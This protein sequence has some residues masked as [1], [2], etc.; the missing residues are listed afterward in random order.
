MTRVRARDRICVVVDVDWVDEG[1]LCNVSGDISLKELL[2]VFVVAILDFEHFLLGAEQFI[3]AQI[4]QSVANV[5]VEKVYKGA[6]VVVFGECLK[7]E[8]VTLILDVFGR[9][10]P[11]G[12]SPQLIANLVDSFNEVVLGDA[13]W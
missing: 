4:G 5:N 11:K 9:V 6:V 2:I 12:K 13:R 10:V 7:C 8:D 3:A 1:L